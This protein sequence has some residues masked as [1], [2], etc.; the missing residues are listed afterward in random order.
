MRGSIRFIVG[1]LLVWLTV[2]A[3]DQA[4]DIEVFCL[5]IVTIIGLFSMWSGARA[6][7][8]A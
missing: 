3:M 1:L 2:G 8:H 7:K 4:T 6:L 5:S